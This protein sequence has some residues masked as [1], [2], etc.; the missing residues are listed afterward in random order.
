M[1]FMDLVTNKLGWMPP[2][3]IAAL[4]KRLKHIPYV[5]AQI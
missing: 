3:V 2:K 1:D 5:Q 4:E